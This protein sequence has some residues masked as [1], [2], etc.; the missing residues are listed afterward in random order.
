MLPAA[1]TLSFPQIDNPEI[2]IVIPVH[3]QLDFTLKCL[4]TIAIH[5]ARR[6]F[7]VLVVDDTS[8]P[9]MFLRLREIAGYCAREV[10]L[11]YRLLREMHAA[12]R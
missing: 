6:T 11:K 4:A 12:R 10:A 7:E 2:S 8:D 1:P 5:G 9:A 3:N